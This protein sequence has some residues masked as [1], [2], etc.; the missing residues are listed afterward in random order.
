V[1]TIATI[2]DL[3]RAVLIKGSESVVIGDKQCRMTLSA[4]WR[5]DLPEARRFVA[6]EWHAG[7][8]SRPTL[9][10]LR[11]GKTV[12]QPLFK[13]EVWFGPFSLPMEYAKAESDREREFIRD[14]YIAEKARVLNRY[15]YERPLSKGKDGYEPIGPHRFP[16]VSVVIIEDD[17]SQSPVIRLHEHYKIGEFDEAYPLSSFGVREHPDEIKARF[18][19]ELKATAASYE[20]QLAEMRRELAK[21]TGLVQGHVLGQESAKVAAGK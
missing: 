20:G 21:L 11:P 4:S 15:D 16:D 19:A 2:E 1:S 17:G 5:P 7:R 14:K 3:D 12:T 6:L 9:I 13:A 8:G 18:D 10:Q